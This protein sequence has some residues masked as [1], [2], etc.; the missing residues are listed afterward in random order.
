MLCVPNSGPPPRLT[1]FSLSLIGLEMLIHWAS[2]PILAFC[3]GFFSCAGS[4]G[5]EE[6]SCQRCAFIAF[7]GCFAVWCSKMLRNSFR[8]ILSFLGGL[9]G[10]D[11]AFFFIVLAK[12][13]LMQRY[14]SC[15]PG[16]VDH[17]FT[18]FDS[19]ACGCKCGGLVR[20]LLNSARSF[21]KISVR[22]AAS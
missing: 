12:L 15:R 16:E 18:I 3:E 6:L 5:V 2:G 1:G 8:A 9:Q 7:R 10:C 4:H 21:E 13:R 20:P 22:R 11:E 14:L 17:I 19:F